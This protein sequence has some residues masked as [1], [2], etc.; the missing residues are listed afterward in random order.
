MFPLLYEVEGTPCVLS[1]TFLGVYIYCI[2]AHGIY[3]M[4]GA[5]FLKFSQLIVIKIVK[6]VATDVKF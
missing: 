5:I 6:I 1:P 3:W 4:I 2:N